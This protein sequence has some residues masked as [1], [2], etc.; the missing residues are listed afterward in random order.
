MRMI[1]KLLVIGGM[2]ALAA[3]STQAGAVTLL[4]I[5]PAAQSNTSFSLTFTAT[6]TST[7]LSVSGY[8]VPDSET[9]TINAVRRSGGAN[10]LGQTWVYTP[11]ASGANA[12]QFSDNTGVNSLAFAGVTPGV[13]DTFSQTF[14]TTVDSEYTYSF[15]FSNTDDNAP[16]GFRVDVAAAAGGVPE[17]ASWAMMI[18]GAAGVGGMM[19]RHQARVSTRV[20]FA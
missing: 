13:Y 11:A 5:N 7:T 4:L 19:R 10:L 18:L 17:P 9:V 2:L 15:L 1:S 16:S 6:A 14:V 3:A 12:G 20:T 8:Q